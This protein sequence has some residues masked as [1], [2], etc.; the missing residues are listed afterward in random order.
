MQ[1]ISKRH[2]TIKQVKF[3]FRD[4][5]MIEETQNDSKVKENS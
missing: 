2:R 3:Y 4:A 5:K 1:K